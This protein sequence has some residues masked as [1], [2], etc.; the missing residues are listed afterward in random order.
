[1]RTLA[2]I[3]WYLFCFGCALSSSTALRF[4][5]AVPFGPSEIL[6]LIGVGCIAPQLL[7]G[8]T[9][10]P[11]DKRLFLL[12]AGVWCSYAAGTG[13]RALGRGMEVEQTRDLLAIGYA[14]GVGLVYRYALKSQA[15]RRIFSDTTLVACLFIVLVSGRLAETA[16]FDIFES[17][18]RTAGFSHNPNQ[19]ALL[20][21]AFLACLFKIDIGRKV[22][23]SVKYVGLAIGML[24]GASSGSDAFVVA[25]AAAGVVVVGSSYFRRA[26]TIVI[27]AMP[28]V[29]LALCVAGVLFGG[30]LQE[31]AF[32]MYAEGNQGQVRFDLWRNGITAWADAPLFGHGV[33]SFSGVLGPYESMEAHNSL[34]DLSA[35]AGIAG[36]VCF[37][38]LYFS[39]T[40]ESDWRGRTG[41]VLLGVFCLFHYVLRNP[42]FWIVLVGSMTAIRVPDR[43]RIPAVRRFAMRRRPVH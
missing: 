34:I 39:A 30:L 19:F 31:R 24:V 27:V 5:T 2:T 11:G 6:V 15:F 3:G 28:L 9:A 16:G 12:V 21:V 20:A 32:A 10:S 38:L 14:A 4:S 41:L 35:S 42:L 18:K 37:L 36:L 23:R 40:R 25:L 7:S 8:G 17:E 22:S 29:I 43:L 13:L 26:R 1:M 33:G